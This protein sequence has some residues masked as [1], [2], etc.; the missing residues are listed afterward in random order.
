MEIYISCPE[1][2]DK[3][4]GTPMFEDVQRLKARIEILEKNLKDCESQRQS[5]VRTLD[6]I[7]EFIQMELLKPQCQSN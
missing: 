1:N 3:P 4:V 7:Q 2:P 5:L 6:N